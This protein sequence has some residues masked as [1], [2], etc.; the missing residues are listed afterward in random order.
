MRSPST[1]PANLKIALMIGAMGFAWFLFAPIQFGGRVA[2][3]IVNGNSMEPVYYRG[4]LVLIQTTSSYQIGDIVTYQHPEIGPVIHRIIGREGE[5]WIFQGDHN[6][7][8]DPYRPVDADLIGRAWVHIPN[9]GKWL[10]Q[11]RQSPLLLALLMTGG[12]II[13]VRRTQAEHPNRTQRGTPPNSDLRQWA[14]TL[15]A[16]LAVAGL[17]LAGFAFTRP[18]SKAGVENLNYQHQARFRYSADAPAGLYDS[19]A[20]YSGDPIFRQLSQRL[21]VD[22]EY[23]FSSDQAVMVGGR[24]GMAVV[25]SSQ[26]G[27]RRTIILVEDQAIQSTSL[28]IHSE[29]ELR[30]LN[31]IIAQFE[32]Q[33][34][35]KNQQF[36]LA[37]I[38]RIELEGAVGGMSVQ[39]SFA[40]PLRFH[41]DQLQ[42]Q[43]ISNE[44]GSDPLTPQQQGVLNR[45]HSEAASMKLLGITMDVAQARQIGLIMAVVAGGLVAL[46]ALPLLHTARQ[47][48]VARIALR[49]GPL[50]IEVTGLP[51]LPANQ[52]V[53][54]GSFEDLAKL[55]ERHGALIMHDTSASQPRYFMQHEQVLYVYG[56]PLEAAPI[57]QHEQPEYEVRPKHAEPPPQEPAW[58]ADFLHAL[59]ETGLAAD[60]CRAIGID[61]ITVYHERE[62]SAEFAQA[63]KDARLV[64]WQRRTLKG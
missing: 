53:Q 24:Y 31:E 41:V 40:P 25:L 13:M 49:Y 52:V 48:E 32:A 26:N 58:Q 9:L 55:A 23:Q 16:L 47:D 5:R 11:V 34:G 64:A 8:I 27:W 22:F 42:I 1:L 21:S 62:R 19:S 2:A 33:T 14:M 60:A 7:Y 56:A 17:A 39:E 30:R 46:L 20:A 29:I 18:T 10:V 15:L 37:F 44:D 38:P 3:I 35:L 54:I 61:I 43:M 57:V 51:S 12:V 45:P 4:D 63:W 6:D 59:R 36:T 50:L 28:S